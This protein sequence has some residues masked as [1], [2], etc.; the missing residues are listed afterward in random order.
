[1]SL[2]QVCQKQLNIL[3]HHPIATMVHIYNVAVETTAWKFPYVKV[4]S[5]CLDRNLKT[6]AHMCSLYPLSV[7]QSILTEV[8]YARQRLTAF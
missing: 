1:M 8:E 5:N 7:Y 2:L 3:Y 4:C 6:T